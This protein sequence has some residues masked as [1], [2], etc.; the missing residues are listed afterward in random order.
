MGKT[1]CCLGVLV[2][3]FFSI[4]LMA[5]SDNAPSIS[6]VFATLSK[7]LDSKSSTIG[8]EFAMETI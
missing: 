4:S 1:T 6:K 5:Q 7:S 3:F 8:D 2:I